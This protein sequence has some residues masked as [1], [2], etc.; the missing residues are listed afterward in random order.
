MAVSIGRAA[1]GVA[2]MVA[3]ERIAEGWIGDAGRSVRVSVL[4]RSLGARDVALGG[5]AAYALLR[6]DDDAARIWLATQAFS[7]VVDFIGTLAVR[8]RLPDSGVTTTAALAGG[9]AAIAGAAAATI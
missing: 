6:G 3:P 1:F 8:E 9:S 2:M 4:T 7:D 5:G